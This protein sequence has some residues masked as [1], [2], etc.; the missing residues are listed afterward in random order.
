M[1]IYPLLQWQQFLFLNNSRGIPSFEKLA[2]LAFLSIKKQLND[3][4]LLK[5]S[6]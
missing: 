4:L 2:G 5:L 3:T 6:F 1:Q